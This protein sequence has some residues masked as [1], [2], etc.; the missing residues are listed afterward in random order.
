MEYTFEDT[1]RI[2]YW[3]SEKC[4]YCKTDIFSR[5][6]LWKHKMKLCTTAERTLEEINE[7]LKSKYN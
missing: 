5:A 1:S 4:P 3:M 6:D 2:Q 7:E